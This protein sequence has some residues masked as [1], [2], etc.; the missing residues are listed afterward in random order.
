MI[1]RYLEYWSLEEVPFAL[2]PDP[3]M[4]YLSKQHKEC[5]IRLKYAFYSN[6]GGALLISENAG[7]GKTTVVNRFIN[8]IREDLL[9]NVQTCIINHPTLT[10]NQLIQEVCLQFGSEKPS[11]SRYENLNQ[12]KRLLVEAYEKGNKAIVVVDEGQLLKNKYSTLQE[13][14]TLL[15]F[16]I[17]GTFLLTFVLVGQKP[18]E[19]TIRKIPEFWQRLPVRFF[20]DSLDR[21]DTENLVKYRLRKAGSPQP[22]VFTKEAYDLV[23]KYSQGCPRVICSI[24]DVCLLIGYT[25]RKKMLDTTIVQAAYGDM[26]KSKEGFHYFKFLQSESFIDDE[27]EHV[28]SQ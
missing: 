26:V 19:E 7:D 27:K 12:L 18:L 17:E 8:D 6:K 10:P 9:G 13:L 24:A 21:G 5:L 20:L 23:Y 22:D 15:N 3:R 25:S 28:N 16:C 2:S 4:L 14:R 1:K 11:K